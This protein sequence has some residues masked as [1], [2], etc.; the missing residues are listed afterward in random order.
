MENAS[1]ALIIAGAT[2]IAVLLISLTMWFL[3]VLRNYNTVEINNKNASEIESFNRY[4]L[5]VANDG[6]QVDGIT[7]LNIFNKV[8][9]FNDTFPQYHITI[10][11]PFIFYGDESNPVYAF[12]TEMSPGTY[13][14]KMNELKDN[15]QALNIG[16]NQKYTYH[17]YYSSLEDG[18]DADGRIRR[19]T[20][21]H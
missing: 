9:D 8:K 6:D 15:L 16:Y 2:L 14:D 17:Y 1:K 12:S 4:F 7:A 3:S 5:Y 18:S 11:N 21:V 13:L 20:L 19:I 10:D